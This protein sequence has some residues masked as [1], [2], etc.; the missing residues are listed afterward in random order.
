MYQ[1]TKTYGPELGL[2]AC[3]RQWRAKSHCRKLHGYALSF[4]FTFGCENLDENG[5]VMD[6][7]ACKPI[8]SWL[9][10]IF[11]HTVL[12]AADDPLYEEFRRL[13]ELDLIKAVFVPRVGVESFAQFVFAY[14][15]GMVAA[16]T[17]GRVCLISVEVKEHGA[18]GAIYIGEEHE[19]TIQP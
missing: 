17:Q 10:E 3:F 5:W 1:S 8:K 7:G 15:K 6:F 4:K 9:E 19:L 16:I 2:S 11:D 13:D 12:V 18:N 14:A